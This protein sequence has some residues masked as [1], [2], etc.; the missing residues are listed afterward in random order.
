[1]IRKLPFG[2]FR[3]YSHQARASS[4]VRIPLRQ[5]VIPSRPQAR[6]AEGVS[7]SRP[8][9]KPCGADTLVGQSV[10]PHNSRRD[11]RP[12]PALSEVEGAV[13]LSEPRQLL[14]SRRPRPRL[15]MDHRWVPLVS[16]P[17]RDVG[18]LT[19]TE[20]V[21]RSEV[22][23]RVPRFLRALCARGGLC[24]HTT[25]QLLRTV[26]EFEWHRQ[27]RKTSVQSDHHP[28]CVSKTDLSPPTTTQEKLRCYA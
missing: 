15:F 13:R 19:M 12:K 10:H 18:E 25:S 27:K 2:E 6:S 21:I 16:P 1:M 22:A 7:S 24:R 9:H 20:F 4:L 8:H 26:G 3:L 28:R 14:W 23:V 17:L 11:S 5:F